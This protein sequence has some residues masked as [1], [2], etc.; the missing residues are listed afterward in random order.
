[1][2]GKPEVTTEKKAI[3]DAEREHMR[4]LLER[5]ALANGA[6]QD[7]YA[8]LKKQHGVTQGWEL[9]QDLG[10][11]IAVKQPAANGAAAQE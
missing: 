6:V 11:F 1:M 10:G 5:Q 7:F 8:F 4:T 2:A 9:S 3:T